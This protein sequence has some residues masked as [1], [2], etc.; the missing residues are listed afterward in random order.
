MAKSKDELRNRWR[1]AEVAYRELVEQ[2][3]ADDGPKLSKSD[4]VAIATAR[5]KADRRMDEYFRRTLGEESPR[6]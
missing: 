1:A 6:A 4:A 5:S 2:H 3:L